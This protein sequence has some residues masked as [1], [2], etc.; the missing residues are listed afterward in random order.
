MPEG[1]II[2]VLWHI[3][4]G[5]YTDSTDRTPAIL[6]ACPES[7]FMALKNYTALKVAPMVFSSSSP[8]GSRQYPNQK[9]KAH[10]GVYI[11]PSK[12]TLYYSKTEWSELA[13]RGLWDWFLRNLEAEIAQKL[14]KLAAGA[15]VTY[16][17]SSSG[18]SVASVVGDPGGVLLCFPELRSISIILSD[19]CYTNSYSTKPGSY[20]A[21]RRAPLAIT[22]INLTKSFIIATWDLCEGKA[23][24]LAYSPQTARGR[25]I[26][27]SAISRF[28]QDLIGIGLQPGFVNGMEINFGKVVRGDSSWDGMTAL[29]EKFEASFRSGEPTDG[30]E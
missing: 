29:R 4:R 30:S 20:S 14:Q 27:A 15:G 23:Q 25:G 6:H 13:P 8:I 3:E 24:V 22:N 10:L 21:P 11:D 16:Y 9:L 28:R 2:E 19:I 12:D 5:F 26:D 17:D 18:T 1:R 7:R